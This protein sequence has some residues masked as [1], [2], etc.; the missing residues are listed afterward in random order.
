MGIFREWRNPEGQIRP[1]IKDSAIRAGLG[2]LVGGMGLGFGGL[3]GY[4]VAVVAIGSG[5]YNAKEFVDSTNESEA[6]FRGEVDSGAT[7]EDAYRLRAMNGS[8]V[9]SI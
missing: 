8:L 5:I 4:V 2:G 3:A 7:F 6:R 9:R 1:K